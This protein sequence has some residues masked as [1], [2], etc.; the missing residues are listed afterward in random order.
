V[1]GQVRRFPTRL[2]VVS[3]EPESRAERAAAR[4]QLDGL[5]IRVADGDEPAFADL[6]DAVAGSVFGLAKRVL[7]QAEQ[8]E[9]VAQ[10]VLLEVWQQA[11]RFDPGRGSGFAWV[12]TVA[13]RRAVDRVRSAQSASD[14]ER[15]VGQRNH[16][17]EH[18]QV[19]E[20][21]EQ[22]MEAE[23]VRDCM[24]SLT[25]VQKQSV[26]M[27]YYEG[28]TYPEVAERLDAPL[29]TIKTRMR[30]GLI[31]LRDCLGVSA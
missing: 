5:L 22:R 31:R 6:Y 4:R 23:A 27:A 9:E 28:M 18:D 2:H 11:A 15:R 20:L 19:A 12:M 30:D 24:D 26:T 17:R 25:E 10:E 16:E 7:R 3:E 1:G 8:A 14:R 21:V 29:G 13:H